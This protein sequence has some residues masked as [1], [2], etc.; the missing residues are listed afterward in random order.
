MLMRSLAAED[1]PKA[2]RTRAAL[3]AAA[4]ERAA[5]PCAMDRLLALTPDG[6][7]VTLRPDGTDLTVLA[8]AAGGARHS[9][10]PLAR[11]GA[12]A[13]RCARR[14]GGHAGRVSLRSV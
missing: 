6:G 3:A 14:R 5:A 1:Y 2:E 7:V 12:G 8:A 9:Q 4:Q 11:W 10:V 13:E